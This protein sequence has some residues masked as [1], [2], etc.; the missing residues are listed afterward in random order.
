MI[1]S[2]ELKET[3]KDSEKALLHI[4][5]GGLIFSV[6]GVVSFLKYAEGLTVLATPFIFLFSFGLVLCLVF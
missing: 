5:I 6:I 3:T 1:N 4:V 2:P